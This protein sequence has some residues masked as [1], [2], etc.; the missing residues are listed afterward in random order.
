[1]RKAAFRLGAGALGLVIAC[2]I[3]EIGLRLAGYGRCSVNPI[4]GFH[5]CDLLVGWRGR[6]NA[7][8]R[9]CRPEFDVTVA[10]NELGFRRHE[11]QNPPEKCLHKVFVL[12]DSFTWGWGVGQGKV[13][14]DQMNCLLPECDVQ[15]FGLDGTGTVQQFAVFETYVR[16]RLSPGDTVVLNFCN[17]DFGDNIT[18]DGGTN[19]FAKIVDGRIVVVPPNHMACNPTMARLKQCSSLINLIV[20]SYDLA[21]A[22]REARSKADLFGGCGAPLPDDSPA[23]VITSEF[24]GRFQK[25]CQEK[26]ARFVVA[27]IP[28][29]AE[30]GESAHPSDASLRCDETARRLLAGCTKSQGIETIDF[31]PDFLAAR[32]SGRFERLAFLKDQHWNES[33]HTLAAEVIARHLADRYAFHCCGESKPG[34]N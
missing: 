6:P 26:G 9:F 13:F 4:A 32:R 30:L 22:M 18:D 16:D 15:N 3:G 12:G 2:A 8:G 31:L 19:L 14:T 24:L 29:M 1:M 10:H 23:V 11:H 33:G 34:G 17:N 28:G 7:T 21:L 5:E 20:Y 25:A 27:H